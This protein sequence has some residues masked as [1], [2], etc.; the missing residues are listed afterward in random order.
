MTRNGAPRDAIM[1]RRENVGR[2]RLRGLS[3][4][5]V[6]IALAQMPEP[7]IVTYGTVNRDL[8]VLE[9]EWRANA[10]RAIDEYQAN[11]LAEIAEGKRKCWQLEDMAGLARFLKLEADIRGTNAPVKQEITGAGGGPLVVK[12]FDYGAA[13]AQIATGSEPDSTTPGDGQGLL[14]GAA[15][16]KNGHGGGGCAGLWQRRR[17]PRPGRSSG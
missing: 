7:I 15:V 5:E 10:A 1:R 12:A 17:R 13:V 6:A 11:Q 14:D 4:R 3:L 2:L 8:K 16:R 9:A